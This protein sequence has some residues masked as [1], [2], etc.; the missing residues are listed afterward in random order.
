MKIILRISHSTF[1]KEGVIHM[2]DEFGNPITTQNTSNQPEAEHTSRVDPA[3]RSQQTTIFTPA[4]AGW[5]ETPITRTASPASGAAYPNSYRSNGTV[6]EPVTITPKEK[7]AKKAKDKRQ[8]SSGGGAFRIIALILVCAILGGLAGFGGAAL[9]SSKHPA[10]VLLP[11]SSNPSS[12]TTTTISDGA[13]QEVPASTLYEGNREDTTL[14]ISKID[15]DRLMSAAEVYAANVNSTVGITTSITVNYWGYQSTAAASGSGFILT[16]DGYILTNYHVI[17]DSTSITVTCYDN[18]TYEAEVIGY[19]GSNDI[20]VLKVDAT[21]LTPVILGDSSKL[22]VGDDVIA[23]GNPLGEL[24]FSL[25]SGIVSALNR[26]V[27]LSTN[28]TMNLI[29]T[30]CAINAGN[31]GGA[32]FNMYGEVVGITNAKYSSNG[33]SSEASIDNI[34]FAIPINSVRGIVKSIIENGFITKP[35][36]GVSVTTVSADA[37]SYGLPAGASVRSITADSPAD[38]AGLQENDIITAVDGKPITTSTEL[39]TTVTACSPGDVLNMTVYRNSEY[40]TITITVGETIQSAKAKEDAAANS[41]EQNPSQNPNQQQSQQNQQDQ[42][43]QQNNGNSN[44]WG[45]NFGDNGW[46]FNFGD[47]DWG[48]NW[49]N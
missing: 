19:D 17:E 25:T 22:N 36:I 42:Q 5:V 4:D 6:Y 26:E 31:S 48:F 46:G 28:V 14:S 30:D 9:Y 1:F 37:Q 13:S 39:V 20:A 16:S 7:K 34:G 10:T 21:G 3:V 49:G 11:D 24:T 47:N 12:G 40:I 35:Y 38:K 44:G 15:T 27:T 41:Q 43:S 29:Q 2:Y 32:L 33:N 8:R 18:T 45:F 23:I